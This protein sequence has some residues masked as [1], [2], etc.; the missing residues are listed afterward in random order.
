M[1]KGQYW[2]TLKI[3]ALEI[4]YRLSNTFVIKKSTVEPRTLQ[5]AISGLLQGCQAGFWHLEWHLQMAE[6]D[7]FSKIIE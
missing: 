3:Q 2:K 5:I 7:D 4:V 1:G 6:I